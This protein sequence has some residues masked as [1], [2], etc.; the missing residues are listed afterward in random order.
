MNAENCAGSSVIAMLSPSSGVGSEDLLQIREIIWVRFLDTVGV[1]DDDT[2][3]GGGG[4]G[5]THGHA[6]VVV[7]VDLGGEDSLGGVDAEGV[8]FDFDLG[9]E[10]FEFGGHGFDAIGFLN[11]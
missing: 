8:A 10:A 5:K 11:A 4:K 1:L 6:V 9:A 7:G 2:R 3:S